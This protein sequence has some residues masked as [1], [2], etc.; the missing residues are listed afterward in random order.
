MVP[1]DGVLVLLFV[2]VVVR[3]LPPPLEGYDKIFGLKNGG[4]YEG[5][6]GK[7]TNFASRSDI[8]KSTFRKHYVMLTC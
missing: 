6:Q 2:L 4:F 8:S 1:H 7:Q 3:L 5:N